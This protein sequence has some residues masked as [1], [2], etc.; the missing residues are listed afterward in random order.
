MLKKLK[1][2]TEHWEAV[3]VSTQKLEEIIPNM[4]APLHFT[5]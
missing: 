4:V 1:E 5:C 3:S 2:N